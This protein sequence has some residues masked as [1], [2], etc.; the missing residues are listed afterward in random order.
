MIVSDNWF[1]VFAIKFYHG[2]MLTSYT[3]IYVGAMVQNCH[4]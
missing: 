3:F 2:L 4:I 1:T